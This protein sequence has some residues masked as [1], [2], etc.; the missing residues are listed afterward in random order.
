MNALLPALRHRTAIALALGAA[1]CSTSVVAAPDQTLSIVQNGENVGSVVAKTEGSH[2]SVDYMVDNNGRGPKH[3]EEIDIGANAIPVAWQIHGTSLM[4]G[5][6]EE[7]FAVKAGTAVWKSQADAGSTEF[8]GPALYVVNDG[9]PW[10]LGVY[11]RALLA[12]EDHTLPTL[13]A[14]SMSLT[15]LE[16]NSFGVADQAISVTAYRLDGVDINPN[17]LMLD[18]DGQL[19][20][21]VKDADVAVRKGYEDEAERLVTLASD[22]EVARI[23]GISSRVAHRFQ[24]PVRIR[25]VHVFDPETGKRSAL[26]T[27]V[28]MRG[29]IT[30]ILP[31]DGGPVPEDEVAIDGDGG[32]LYPGLHDMHYHANLSSGLYSLAVGVTSTRD[33]GNNNPFL[34]DIL[35]RIDARKI[36]SPSI[37]PNGFIEG[38]SPFSAR[39]GKVV[40]TLEEGI[41]AVH[42]YA[43][44]GY[45][46]VKFYNS[47]NPDFV[48][49]LAAEAHRLGMGVTGHI[50]AFYSPD[51]A[52]VD[53][54]DTI[55][56]MNQLMLGWILDPSED[57]RT[58]LRLTAMRRGATLDLS[59]DRVQHTVQLMKEHGTSLGTTTA[60]IEKLMV[61]RAGRG[62]EA[63]DDFIA[64][65]PI[66]YQR[67]LKRSFVSIPDEATDTAYMK[68][69]DKMLEVMDMLHS[70]GIQMLPG[71]DDA[72]G[73]L[74]PREVELYARSG[75]GPAEAL[76]AATIDSARYLGREAQTG[77]I[78]QG[79]LADLVLVP[80][81]PLEDI[82]LIKHPSMVMHDGAIFYPAEIYEALNIKPFSPPPSVTMASVE[83]AGLDASAAA[84]SLLGGGHDH[85]EYD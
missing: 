43:D 17:Y 80:G 36:A 2:V 55:A 74:L 65:T 70:E 15:K 14:G 85:H 50:P 82:T 77:T 47:L 67:Y 1:F 71:T 52:I 28:T 34:Q 11:A 21:T 23:E 29:K 26:S 45:Y 53:G 40:A 31:G 35:T 51:R 42:W 79:K 25:N 76:K 37:T 59:S 41:E 75:M 61:S 56:H 83:P 78:E 24:Q 7:E 57:T 46:Q 33:M 3:A 13:P 18:D 69:A 8:D 6:V 73:F 39:Y 4:G 66:G 12:D 19:F 68:G 16:T 49:P 60:I 20:A 81:D 72:F 48:K 44:R 54:Y 10:A 64:H 84:M 58:A 22:Y 32:T 27:V 5:Q 63:S 62:S 9:S 30:R 38:R